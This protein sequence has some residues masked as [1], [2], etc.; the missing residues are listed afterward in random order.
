MNK[1]SRFYDSSLFAHQ[2]M[3]RPAQ[4]YKDK[5]RTKLN[6]HKKGLFVEGLLEKPA[7]FNLCP[8]GAIRQLWA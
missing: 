3:A 7:S 5:P 8:S 2:I 1:I 4:S 6:P